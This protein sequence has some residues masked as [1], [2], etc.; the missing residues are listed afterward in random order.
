MGDFT[1]PGHIFFLAEALLIES[2]V[3]SLHW[4]C[5]FITYFPTLI[6]FYVLLEFLAVRACQFQFQLV[7]PGK[8]NKTAFPPL[9]VL[10]LTPCSIQTSPCQSFS[11]V[12][13][14]R[15]LRGSRVG[16]KR[17]KMTR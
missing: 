11:L 9:R 13:I 8:Q 12:R 2:F 7:D 3:Y 1:R 5:L 6:F 4:H 10:S 16:A 15:K 17:K 14:E